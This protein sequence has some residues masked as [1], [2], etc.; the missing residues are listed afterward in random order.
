MR[1][2]TPAT[3]L[4]FKIRQRTYDNAVK[5][6]VESGTIEQVSKYSASDE[7]AYFVPH[8]DV[9]RED[10]TTTKVRVVFDGSP[11]RVH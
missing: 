3:S 7:S 6:Q 8:H 2:T 4:S 1:E 5:E 9:I 11:S 10:K